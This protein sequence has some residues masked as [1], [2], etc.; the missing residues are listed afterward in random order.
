LNTPT[1]EAPTSTSDNTNTPYN[2]TSSELDFGQFSKWRMRETSQNIGVH[3]IFGGSRARPG[4]CENSRRHQKCLQNGCYRAAKIGQS[5]AEAA[6]ENSNMSRWCVSPTLPIGCDRAPA[7]AALARFAPRRPRQAG[8]RAV[9]SLRLASMS[10]RCCASVEPN[11]FAFSYHARAIAGS[12]KVPRSPR[13]P[14]ATG[15]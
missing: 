1:I 11:S 13:S 2:A 6:A 14:S 3:G 10:R 15:S 4:P 9:Y 7:L 8:P 5:P 12:A